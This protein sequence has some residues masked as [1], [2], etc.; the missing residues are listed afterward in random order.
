[1]VLAFHDLSELRSY[2]IH[3][4]RAELGAKMCL[5]EIC[6]CPT[7]TPSA[8]LKLTPVV[9][10]FLNPGLSLWTLFIMLLAPHDAP[11]VMEPLVLLSNQFLLYL[12]PRILLTRR[13]SLLFSLHACL[14][15]GRGWGPPD[16]ASQPSLRLV[17]F[18]D[19]L[20]AT[21]DTPFFHRWGPPKPKKRRNFY[22]E[23]S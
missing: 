7:Q 23:F 18:K 8:M 6:L 4:G 1:M 20:F 10:V 16:C 15:R 5:N 22:K 19:F 21:I 3:N 13:S 17:H 12:L 2:A 14:K 9:I 11:L